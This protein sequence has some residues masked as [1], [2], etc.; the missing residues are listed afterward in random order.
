VAQPIIEVRGVSKRY[1]LGQL[2]A[3]SLRQEFERLLGGRSK[4][5][6][7]PADFWALRDVSFDVA[8]GE[9]LGVIGANGA[10]KSTLLK[11]LSRVTAPSLGEIRLRGRIAS[12]LEVGTGFHPE[13]TG[14]ENVF[15][16][17]AILGMTRAEIRR[18]FDQIVDFSGIEPF[19]DTPVKRYS[20]GMYVRLAFAVA[21][22]LEPDILIVDEVLAVGDAAFQEKCIGKMQ[23]DSRLGGRTVLFVTHNMAAL[24]GLCPQSIVLEHGEIAFRGETRQA[25]QYYQRERVRVAEVHDSDS[26]V[27]DGAGGARILSMRIE[28]D[29]G[30][31][32]TDFDMGDAM[33]IVVRAKF[34]RQERSPVFGIDIATDAGVLVANCRSTD[35]GADVGIADGVVEYRV[36]IGELPLYPRVYSV[37]PWIMD[38]AGLTWFDWVRNG[39]EFEVVSGSKYLN[40]AKVTGQHGIVYIPSAWSV[41]SAP[42]LARSTTQ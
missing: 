9:V 12:L 26:W 18:K 30:A 23:T 20:S 29:L 25:M 8:P 35:G 3:T 41:R 14:R 16:N 10:G 13:L 37:Q 15:L 21:A 7:A 27:H 34:E 40:G 24:Q 1:R 31:A 4:A 6:K 38:Q 33:N 19:L 5:A 32:K 36:R 17:G 42:Q 22:H 28:D 39:A 11:L 2:G